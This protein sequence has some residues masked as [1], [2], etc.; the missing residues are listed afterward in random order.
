MRAGF[1]AAAKARKL[2]V[3]SSQVY[4]KGQTDFSSEI[5]NVK[6]A[7]AEVLMTAACWVI[8]GSSCFAQECLL[9]RHAASAIGTMPFSI[10]F[11]PAF[12]AILRS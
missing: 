8:Q 7:G 3:G 1:V 6:Q 9:R 2:Q 12:C 5:L 4:K 10:D 11:D